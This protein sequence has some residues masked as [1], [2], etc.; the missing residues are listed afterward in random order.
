ME[1]KYR[2]CIDLGSSS[3]RI[4]IVY[5]LNNKYSYI[6][7]ARVPNPQVNLNGELRWDILNLFNKLK[8]YIDNAIAEYPIYSI[9]ICSWGVDYCVL[10]SDN[11]LLDLPYSYRDKSAIA[12]YDTLN[13]IVNE[14]Q[15]YK[16]SGV[17]PNPINTIYQLYRDKLTNRYKEHRGLKIL[18]IA[19]MLAYTLTGRIATEITNAS[20]TSLLQLDANAWNY[21]LIETIGIDTT[22]FPELISQGQAYGLYKNIPVIAVCTHDT[23]SA[24]LSMGNTDDDTAIL[25]GGSWL[26]IGKVTDKAECQEL[27]YSGEYT[28]ERGFNNSNMFLNNINGL[29]II[30]RLVAENNL[31]YIDID[32]NIKSA[33]SLGILEPNELMSPHNMKDSI[34]KMLNLEDADIYS[35]IKTVYDSLAEKINKSINLIN[36]IFNIKIKKII[37]TGG[38][39][40][41]E[42]LI[43]RIKTL[44]STEIISS[45]DEGAVIGNAIAQECADNLINI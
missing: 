30:Q 39:M 33:K 1:K 24:V 20:T 13:K 10:K 7:Y 37:M 34:L 2:L 25:S 35:I 15:L 12:A 6:E 8:I 44:T 42:Y 16:E 5:K 14:K 32:N 19:D 4:M 31:N 22:L 41:A 23:A 3:A 21:K 29:F 28:N 38:A 36:K 43:N 45:Y 26:L 40:R 17:I 27:A 11:T 9:G 18:M